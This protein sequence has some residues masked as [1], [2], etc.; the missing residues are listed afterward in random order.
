MYSSIVAVLAMSKIVR[1]RDSGSPD[2]LVNTHC[3]VQGH[4]RVVVP[5]FRTTTLGLST[6][7]F[8]GRIN[9]DMA[10]QFI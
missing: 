6:E 4:L 5:G 8:T 3:L 2:E 7:H 1:T 9:S 10:Q